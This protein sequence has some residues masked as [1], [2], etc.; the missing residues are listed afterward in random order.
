MLIRAPIPVACL[1]LAG[2]ANLAA[3]EGPSPLKGTWTIV[4]LWSP[5]TILQR[6]HLRVGSPIKIDKMGYAT[7]A[8]TGMDGFVGFAFASRTEARFTEN[9]TGVVYRVLPDATG[10]TVMFYDPKAPAAFV[11]ARKQSAPK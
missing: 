8:R 10:A 4:A 6:T 7:I 2:A 3:N 11:A 9:G 1:L 5:T